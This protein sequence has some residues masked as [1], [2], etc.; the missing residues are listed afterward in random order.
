[1]YSF[2]TGG[3]ALADEVIPVTF[4]E[5]KVGPTSPLE[6]NFRVSVVGMGRLTEDDF[7]I[8]KVRL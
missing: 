5:G 8:L 1:M 2:S 6:D 4:L 7:C 3:S